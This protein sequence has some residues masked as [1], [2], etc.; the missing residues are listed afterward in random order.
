MH[1][2]DFSPQLSSKGKKRIIPW[3][4]GGGGH[5]KKQEKGKKTFVV[6]H[7]AVR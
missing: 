5:Q 1:E 7:A 4:R 3:R 2:L 6:I